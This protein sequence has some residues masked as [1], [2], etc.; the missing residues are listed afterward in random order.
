MTTISLVCTVRDEADNIAVL[1]D[2]MLAQ[3]RL[4]DEIVINDCRSRD[5]TADIVR[6]Y[7]AQ[8]A[9]IKL[10]SGG[11][12]ISSGRNNAISHATGDIIACTDA[13]LVLDETWLAQIVAPLEQGAADLAGGFFRPLP[14]SLFE[15]VIG[16]TNYRHASEI[17]PAAFLPSGN[18]MAFLKQVWAEVGGFPE[19][20]DHCEDLLFDMA[21]ERA[22]YRRIFVSQALVYF[23]PRS[24][25]RA[26]ARQ[27]FFYARGDGL[28]G[29]WPKRHA[30]RYGVYA[31]AAAL[32]ALAWRYSALR[33]LVALL[34]VVG[35]AGYIRRPSMRLWPQTRNLSPLERVYALAL[36]PIIRVVGDCAKMLGYPAGVR[37]RWFSARKVSSSH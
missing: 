23:Y 37:R 21:A 26:F 24:S 6:A 31:T 33:W 36:V 34:L 9:R 18:S 25:L 3:Q 20:A 7:A 30:I 16:A 15:L 4:P 2:S 17:D 12:N 10:V 35:A 8:D 13:G 28:A 32:L 14:R 5:N 1:L 19:W 22:G 27:Y 11:H 29:L